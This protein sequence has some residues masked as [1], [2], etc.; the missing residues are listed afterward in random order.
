MSGCPALKSAKARRLR[1]IRDVFVVLAALALLGAQALSTLHFVLV[2]HH[3]CA[4]HGILED[5]THSASAA[6]QTVNDE[7]STETATNSATAS[8]THEACSV[9]TRPVHTTLP[10]HPALQRA[11]LTG[12]KVAAVA[13]GVWEK[14]DRTALLSSAPKTSPPARG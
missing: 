5:G 11:Q 1:V 13:A 12:P 8:D 2:P 9:A 14:T 10:A 4:L 7:R 3:L 6:E